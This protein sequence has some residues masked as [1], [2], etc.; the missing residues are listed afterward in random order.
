MKNLDEED[1]DP[2][3]PEKAHKLF[4]DAA[5]TAGVRLLAEGRHEFTLKDGRSF[6][7]FASPYTPA[8]GGYA[9]AYDPEEDYWSRIPNNVDIVMTHGPPR[10]PQKEFRLDLG[11]EDEHCG[12]PNLWK[13]IQ[14]S[15]PKLH[16]FGHIHEGHGACTV[17]WEEAGAARIENIDT[18]ASSGLK[19]RAGDSGRNQTLLVNAA[20]MTHGE[21]PNNEP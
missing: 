21:E 17:R 12:C 10:A 14:R 18:K 15:K 11:H 19:V 5:E 20:I 16:C 8:F 7:L 1:D 3:E 9:F 4:R 13:H 6:S 2:N